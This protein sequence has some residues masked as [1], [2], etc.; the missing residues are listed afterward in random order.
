MRK[1]FITALVLIIVLGTTL[2]VIVKETRSR[3]Q[4]IANEQAGETLTGQ[5]ALGDWT[6]DAPGVRRRITVADLPKPYATRSVDNGPRLVKRPPR[7]LATSTCRF[8]GGRV[9]NRA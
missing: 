2:T 5:G 6:T 9:L 4:R 7:R 8:Q 1:R 3:Q